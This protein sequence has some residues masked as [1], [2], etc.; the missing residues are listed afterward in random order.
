MQID[1]WDEN[2][3]V[4]KTNSVSGV[5]TEKKGRHRCGRISKPRTGL[6]TPPSPDFAQTNNTTFLIFLLYAL[7][8]T[9]G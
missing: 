1:R 8:S 6:P 2:W 5:E 9:S 7:T 4:S 3:K